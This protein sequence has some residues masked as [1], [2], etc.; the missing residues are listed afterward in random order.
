[1]EQEHESQ[2]RSM[3]KFISKD[4]SVQNSTYKHLD[5]LNSIGTNDFFIAFNDEGE[6]EGS[7]QTVHPESP[8]APIIED[9]IRSQYESR[10]PGKTLN[11]DLS[12][13]ID[14]E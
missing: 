8:E 2:L 3:V 9:E 13:S 10:F 14:K 12:A 5:G 1:M 4:V 11:K 6:I 7:N